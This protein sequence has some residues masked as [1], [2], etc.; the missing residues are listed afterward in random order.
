ML[1]SG[2][3]TRNGSIEHV[4]RTRLSVGFFLINRRGYGNTFVSALW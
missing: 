4:K 2:V 1:F 3:R